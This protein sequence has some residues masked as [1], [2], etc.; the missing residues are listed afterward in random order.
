MI[1][2]TT[3]MDKII[4]HTDLRKYYRDSLSKP[5]ISINLYANLK[6]IQDHPSGNSQ[7]GL[8]PPPP[9]IQR[10]NV[11]QLQGMPE[12]LARSLLNLADKGIW[13]AKNSKSPTGG[14]TTETSN[15][16]TQ[17]AC[18]KPNFCI[19]TFK[20]VHI[21]LLPGHSLWGHDYDPITGLKDYHQVKSV[22]DLNI[23]LNG[24]IIHHPDCTSNHVLRK[25]KKI[26]LVQALEDTKNTRS[27]QGKKPC[28]YCSKRWDPLN[29]I[30][31]EHAHVKICTDGSTFRGRP[32]G[33]G[34]IFMADNIK[35]NDLWK[36]KGDWWTISEEDNYIA[37]LAAIHKAIRA[38]PININTTIFSDS[39]SCIQAIQLC[40]DSGPRFNPLRKAGRPYILAI[41]KAIQAREKVGA[42]TT[43]THV[44][45]HSGKRD[46]ASVGNAA[47]DYTARFAA[48]NPS[49][50]GS[51]SMNLM[52]HDLNF[53]IM[54]N[55]KNNGDSSS[56]I[57]GD[58][59]K[60]IKSH[61]ASLNDQTWA[62]R[63]SRGALIKAYPKQVD[64]IIKAVWKPGN[65]LSS[66]SVTMA[67][68]GLTKSSR[69]YKDPANN[70]AR[71]PCHRCGTGA[72][73]SAL[74]ALHT[75]PRNASALNDRD[76]K[77]AE[78]LG[79]PKN[80]PDHTHSDLLIK[81]SHESSEIVINLLTD[82]TKGPSRK[83]PVSLN[84]SH[85]SNGHSLPT[86]Q[87]SKGK[88]KRTAQ[89]PLSKHNIVRLLSIQGART[90][91][92]QNYLSKSVPKE[93]WDSTTIAIW[94]SFTNLHTKPMKWHAID[95]R[96]ACRD[97]LRTYSDL[98]YNPII[99]P[100]PWGS[101][102]HSHSKHDE[103]LGGSWFPTQSGF[104]TNRYSIV[105]L[106]SDRN[107]QQ[108]SFTE[109]NSAMLASTQPARVI[110]W[111]EDTTENRSTILNIHSDKARSHILAEAPAGSVSLS[112]FE[113]DQFGAHQTAKILN[114]QALILVLIENDT[115]PGFNFT[116]FT[117]S[118]SRDN[119]DDISFFPCPWSY[120][121]CPDDLPTR[122]PD[123]DSERQPPSTYPFM[124]WC[125]SEIPAAL[126]P[127]TGP[128][129][130]TLKHTPPANRP[131]A[132]D[133]VDPILSCLGTT[134]SA[135]KSSHAFFA[136]P[137]QFFNE[138]P[139][140]TNIPKIIFSTTLDIYR[141]CEAMRKW[142]S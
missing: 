5:L 1:K 49:K 63:K 15:I 33:V 129:A 136:S 135:I 85:D 31:F 11:R 83:S 103:L 40:I 113:M 114:K 47:A 88:R 41:N 3:V 138:N 119:E 48:L 18:K 82:S 91:D 60:A 99:S 109:A 124:L 58:I 39:L 27:C 22:L 97:S 87:S 8:G 21:P 121:P 19:D 70:F 102:W 90:W 12:D 93:T 123:K 64:K 75:C 72:V 96:T 50:K 77:I 94:D 26:P 32:S 78:T 23:I 68:I 116:T 52:A 10:P 74:H 104:L 89:I 17:A 142:K 34:L 134:S 137:S 139:P 141:K 2:I 76:A 25:G 61:M 24:S 107:Q 100:N 140:T 59:R 132:N 42:S 108:S 115:A 105:A 126:S 67:L 84:F 65:P 16:S 86:P 44:R 130:D 118:L 55:G 122:D 4:R 81:Y 111:A 35:C 69:K 112:P 56:P 20:G 71:E 57:H 73:L 43:L 13:I 46:P 106:S 7:P 101:T 30:L 133:T 28:S 38:P 45:S 125:R 54:A 95:W 6:Q 9:K 36:I 92:G 53:I 62:Q 120:P 80:T 14:K 110:I 79:I 127:S 131:T 51:T 37:E 117:E 29:S 66:D 98:Y 128:L